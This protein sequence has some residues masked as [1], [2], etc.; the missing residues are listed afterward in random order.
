MGAFET[1]F[2][3]SFRCVEI[4][5]FRHDGEDKWIFHI[6]DNIQRLLTLIIFVLEEDLLQNRAQQHLKHLEGRR[7]EDSLL[8]YE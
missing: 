8:I 3:I 7:K 5:G 1:D 2:S 4:V 6:S